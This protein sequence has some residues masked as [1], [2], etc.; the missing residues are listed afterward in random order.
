MDDDT[1]RLATEAAAWLGI[2]IEPSLLGGV[3]ASLELLR[4]HAARVMEF[5]LPPGEE[6]APVFAAEPPVS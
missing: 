2:V 4:R 1:R 3:A 5:E 6:A